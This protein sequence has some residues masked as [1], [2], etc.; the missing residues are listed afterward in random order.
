MQNLY[1]ILSQ[2]PRLQRNVTLVSATP[3]WWPGLPGKLVHSCTSRHFKG[4]G[5]ELRKCWKRGPGTRGLGT[6]PG[7]PRSCRAGQRGD[8]SLQRPL[9]LKGR[10]DAQLC[11]PAGVSSSS[12]PPPPGGHNWFSNPAPRARQVRDLRDPAG[13]AVRRAG[14]RCLLPLAA[15]RGAAGPEAGRSLKYLTLEAR[16]TNYLE[17][18]SAWCLRD[19]RDQSHPSRLWIMGR[20][21]GSQGS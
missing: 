14:S 13:H 20:C 9:L 10:G 19:L 15:F 4:G 11:A 17:P 21:G 16:G 5:V 8:G 7:S 18:T 1:I 6:G 2:N 12:C 3:G